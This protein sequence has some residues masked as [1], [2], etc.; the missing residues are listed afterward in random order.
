MR[1]AAL[2]AAGATLSPIRPPLRP[3]T[4]PTRLSVG[5]RTRAR[6][7]RFAISQADGP[8]TLGRVRVLLC[9]SKQ[10]AYIAVARVRETEA[11]MCGLGAEVVTRCANCALSQDQSVDVRRWILTRYCL[12]PPA[13][14]SIA[15]DDMPIA[16][17]LRRQQ[18]HRWSLAG[19]QESFD[20][21]V[22]H[23][24]RRR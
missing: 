9:C 7:R 19:L 4:A 2:N 22:Q 6:G 14:P 18:C 24:R 20:V 8:R 1:T 17:T 10:D 16:W 5:R 15:S 23:R 13:T 12:L 11:P 21:P 3:I